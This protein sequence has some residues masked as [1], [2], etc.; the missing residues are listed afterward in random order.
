MKPQEVRE[1][2][3]EEIARRIQEE[4]TELSKLRFNHAIAPLDNS[5]VLR[6]KRRDIARMKT[7]LREREMAEAEE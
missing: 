4:Q 7:I 3:S 6:N 2:S 5:M 1:M